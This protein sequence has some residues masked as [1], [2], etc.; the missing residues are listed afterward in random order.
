MQRFS[1]RWY[2]AGWVVGNCLTKPWPI[3]TYVGH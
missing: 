1:Y 2:L 3:M